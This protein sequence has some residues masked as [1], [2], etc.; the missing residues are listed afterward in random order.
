MAQ[1][2]KSQNIDALMAESRTYPP[3]PAFTEQANAGT[4]FYD[5]DPDAFWE[6]RGR[7]R[8]S[9]FTD[10]T[11]LKEWDRPYAKWYLGG[12]LNVCYNC[13][14][15]HMENGLE[16]TRSPVLVAAWWRPGE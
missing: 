1:D 14:D 15:R 9:W 8:L 6:T 4:G 5:Q 2:S 10:F 7:E 12:K 3:E 13:V 16:A 11:T